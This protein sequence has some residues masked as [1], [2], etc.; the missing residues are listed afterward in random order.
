MNMT[1]ISQDYFNHSLQRK[2]WWDGIE[3][4]LADSDESEKTVKLWAR[5]VWTLELSL[6]SFSIF[7]VESR[8]DC[9]IGVTLEN[10]SGFVI[11][12][13]WPIP[14]SSIVVFI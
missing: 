7:S 1:Y 2:C 4:N 8:A 12:V 5:R 6:V 3:V 9:H 11:D 10:A 14:L 13:F